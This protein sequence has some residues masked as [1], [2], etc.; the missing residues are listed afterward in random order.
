MLLIS[1]SLEVSH[2]NSDHRFSSVYLLLADKTKHFLS[3]REPER[4][5]NFSVLS[6]TCNWELH[7]CQDNILAGYFDIHCIWNFGVMF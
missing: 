1:L 6:V 5:F 3:E 4:V 2:L 7:A